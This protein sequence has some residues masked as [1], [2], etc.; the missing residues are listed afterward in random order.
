MIDKMMADKAEN[1]AAS[2][3]LSTDLSQAY[4]MVNHNLLLRKL[5]QHGVSEGSIELLKNFL[6]NRS[7]FIDVQGVKTSTIP[8]G[9][10]SVIQGSKNASFLYTA[11][12]LKVVFLQQLMTD[13]IV[14]EELT[15]KKLMNH[16]EIVDVVSQ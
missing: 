6:N 2:L 12:N 15:H 10:C 3:V 9:S 5:H 8:L 16:G 11:Y 1:C 7:F 13:A 14:F 4:D